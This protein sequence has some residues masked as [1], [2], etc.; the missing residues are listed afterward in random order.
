MTSW[1]RFS[2]TGELTAIAGLKLTGGEKKAGSNGDVTAFVDKMEG[3]HFNT[4]CFPLRRRPS[5]PQLS[6][7]S[8]ICATAWARV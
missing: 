5:R 8:S 3:I 1:L 4:L 6:P 2:G 7:K